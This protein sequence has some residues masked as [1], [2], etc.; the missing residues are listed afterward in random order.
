M[1]ISK[2]IRELYEMIDT[3]WQRQDSM[4]GRVLLD[5]RGRD[6]CLI[7]EA[8]SSLESQYLEIEP[9]DKLSHLTEGEK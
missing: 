8:L 2:D 4:S 1:K 9:L 3:E 7:K 6:V 5:L